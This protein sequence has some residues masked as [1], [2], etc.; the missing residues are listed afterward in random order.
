MKKITIV[1]SSG[2]TQEFFVESLTVTKN[3][4]GQL[5][6]IEWKPITGKKAPMRINLDKVDGIFSEDLTVTDAM[7]EIRKMMA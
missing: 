4:F 3:G 7:N 5:T 2:A 6:G 1:F